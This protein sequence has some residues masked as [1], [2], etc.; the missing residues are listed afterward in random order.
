M[1]RFISLLFIYILLIVEVHSQSVNEGIYFQAIARDKAGH[2]ATNKDIYV[3]TNIHKL[4]QN[5]TIIFGDLHQ[6][7]TDDQGV[8]GIMIGQGVV[9]KGFV[10][11]LKNIHWN[12]G[13][14][15]LN[16][17]VSIS[18]EPSDLHWDYNKEWV[19]LGTSPFGA[20]PFAMS[21][22]GSTNS[23]IDT[24][25]L[26]L[27]LIKKLSVSDTAKMLKS[28]LRVNDYKPFNGVISYNELINK[29]VLFDGNYNSLLNKPIIFSGNY[30]ELTN[31]PILFDGNYNNLINKPSLFSGDYADLMN[32]PILFSG[33]YNDLS[34]LP[35][36]SLKEINSNKSNDIS[37]DANST[38]KYPS[39]NA[40]K[41]YVDATVLAGAP[42]A[43]A[44]TKGILK[45]SGD[46]TGNALS[47]LISNNAITTNKILDA[48]VTNDKIAFGIQASK[49]GLENV[50]NH[51]QIYNLNGLTTQVQNFGLPGNAGLVPNW[52]SS[53]GTHTLNI[54]LASASSVTAGLISNSDYEHFNNAY[55]NRINAITN[56]GNNGAATI[57]SNILNIPQYSLV[58]LA[59]N[60]NANTIFVGPVSGTSGPASFR[61]LVAADIPNNSA[62][63]TGNA[64]TATALQNAVLINNTAFNG[65]SNISIT[66]NTSNNLTFNN[67]GFGEASG[68]NFNGATSKTISYNTIG[69]SP[70]AGSNNLNTVGTITSGT[71]SASIIGSNVGGAGSNN[72]LLKANGSGIVSTAVAG[73]DF[74]QPLQF[75]SPL[76]NNANSISLPQANSI[77]SGY[78][79]SA[80]WINFNSKI[81]GSVKGVQNG[82]ASLDANGKIPTSQIPAISFS[83]GYVV[84][85]ESA[86][87][88]LANAVVGSIAIRTDN[89]KNYVLSGLPASTLSNW[90]ELLMPANV[91]SVNGYT[92]SN[93]TLT[94]SDI[95]EGSRLYFT[96]ARSRNALSTLAPLNY[97]S[98]TGVFSITS[99]SANSAGYLSSTDWNTF[100][101]KLG[102]FNAQVANSIFAGPGSGINASPSFRL[103]VSADIPNN[104]ANTTGNAATATSAITATKLATPVNIN[105]VPFDGSSNI[106]INAVTN[107]ALSFNSSG[108]GAVSPTSFDGTNAKTISYNSIGASPLAGSNNITTVGTITN[109]VWNGSVID[110]NYGGAGNVNG[111][112]KANGSG[113]VSSASAGTDFENPL[114]FMS[115]F[116]RST[117]TISMQAATSNSNGYL[118]ST[119]WS[120]FNN[121]QVA[122]TA[123]T[124]VN[125]SGGNTINIGQAVASSSSPSFT[126]LTL[127]GLNV[128][129]V[130]TNSA[131]GALSTV[132]TTGTGLV[133]K[134]NTPTLITPNIGVATATSIN[135]GNITATNIVAISD[136]TAKRYKLTMPNTI[137]ASSTTNI[138]LSTG[139]VFTVSM[140]ANIT[141]FTFTNPGVGTYLIKF[142]QD[143]TGNRSISFPSAWKWSGGVAPV[144]TS[145][146]NKTD[147]VTLIYDGT[148]YFAT[149]VKNF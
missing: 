44:N 34:G 48:S 133:V 123:G 136:V 5:S 137:N 120:T 32:K 18:P 41:T 103:L 90:L 71:W 22:I 30:N 20:V 113:I 12:D 92:Q 93:I 75:V 13:P 19:D 96:D 119:D 78:I 53:N 38:I 129:G 63:T 28:Y 95:A 26:N 127:T 121:K 144:L 149:I 51:P 62:N 148:T 33:Q 46:L 130:V 143:A 73:T 145:T 76:Q 124:G 111:I 11:Q 141:N 60:V 139:N 131:A 36:L 45:L 88:A 132:G 56:N 91:T 147:I 23:G 84:T 2:P 27:E 142:V 70:S 55:N 4:N 39:V 58:G 81:D 98:S 85:N 67:S 102:S 114:I 69:A 49:I 125:I 64:A 21:V 59:G 24:A 77:N 108:N 82:V 146:A 3:Q 29:P 66:A 42:D 15:Y 47:P 1:N 6:V 116:S 57:I 128:S 83:S 17:H 31:R 101:N 80:D 118:T 126:G 79:S 107:N 87:L 10:S 37:I 122:M 112:L 100:N 35:D 115:P 7:K 54:P 25:Y 117:N 97:N 109:G 8:F 134:E 61:F 50:T 138:D 140:G 9:N 86:M 110:A 135:A 52:I 65:S 68:V 99:A 94:S 74:Q 89:S 43:D 14:L 105:N 72:G 104:A 16:L 106:T 40:V